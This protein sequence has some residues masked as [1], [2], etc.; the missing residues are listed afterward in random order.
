[1]GKPPLDATI[2]ELERLRCNLCG[3]VFTAN[4]P[5]DAPEQKYDITAGSMIVLLKYGSGLPLYR[6]EKLQEAL[7]IPC[8]DS[9][10]WDVVE[11]TADRVHPA[12]QEL[13]RLAAQGEIVQN[14]DTTIKILSLMKEIQEEERERTGIFTTAIVSHLDGG[15]RIALFFSG[16]K[17]AGENLEQVLQQRPPNLPPPIQMCDALSRNIPEHIRTLLCNCLAHGRRGFVDIID[18]FPDQCRH[19]I[20]AIGKIYH[21]DAITKEEEMSPE[22]RLHY[23]QLHSAPV[24]DALKDWCDDQLEKKKTEPNSGLGKAIKYL[25][26]HWEK[27]TLFLRVPGAPLDNNLCEQCLK[28]IVLLRKNALFFKTEHGAYIG[29]LFISLIHTCSLNGVNPFEYLNALQEHC[30]QV[31]KAPQNWL[32]WNFKQNLDSSSPSPQ[33]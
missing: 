21:H 1:V 16:G 26:K 13:L 31:R 12:F 6:L 32:P 29:E 9:T 30:A 28:R 18:N 14:D 4:M 5:Q 19:V 22:A 3:K 8:S 33:E 23:H 20:E 24:M 25:I 15:H 7:G 17:H 11:K 2:Y 27:L 10:Q